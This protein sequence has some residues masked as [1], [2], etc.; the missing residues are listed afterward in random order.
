MSPSKAHGVGKAGKG[1]CKSR[2]FVGNKCKFPKCRFSHVCPCCNIDH[3]DAEKGCKAWNEAVAKKV[4][5][6]FNLRP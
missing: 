6:E 2:L 5:D 4:A 1:V 3:E